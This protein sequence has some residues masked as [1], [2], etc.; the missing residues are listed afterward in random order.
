MDN[1]AVGV[2]DSG[3]GGLT[4][5]RVL[6]EKYPKEGIVFLGD[7]ARNPYGERPVEEI[8]RFSEAIKDFLLKKDVKMI[9]VAC[10]T[11][12]FNVPPSFLEG[13][14]PVIKMSMNVALPEDA[15]KSLS[16]QRRLRFRLIRTKSILQRRIRKWK[17]SRSLARDWRLPLRGMRIKIP[18]GLFCN[19]Y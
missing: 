12:S 19:P 13:D 6:A 17:P 14:V 9:L 4:V 8:V 10:N 15:E 5:A 18:S 3:V 16:L 1:R 2:M 7:T 11:I